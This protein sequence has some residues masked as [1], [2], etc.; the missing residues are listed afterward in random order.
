LSQQK[1]HDANSLRRPVVRPL[2]YLLSQL[3]IE[4]QGWRWAEG[5][6]SMPSCPAVK[7]S[8]STPKRSPSPPLTTGADECR[9]CCWCR[10]NLCCV[11]VAA[12]ASTPTTVC[13]CCCCRR[14]AATACTAAATTATC[15]HYH[16][17]QWQLRHAQH[18][19]ASRSQH[20]VTVTRHPACASP[21]RWH[22]S[23]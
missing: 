12:I 3:Q 23:P 8:H 2:S 19:L 9:S 5:C 18:T 4:A 14:F 1:Q 21:G 6:C 16:P 13:W 15:C 10:C 22:L 20:H 7:T 17:V 11:G